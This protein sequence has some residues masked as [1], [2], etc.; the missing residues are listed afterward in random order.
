MR[1]GR[2][3]G[4][5]RPGRGGEDSG[6]GAGT[7][8]PQVL[9]PCPPELGRPVQPSCYGFTF[10]ALGLPEVLALELLGTGLPSADPGLGNQQETADII[11]IIIFF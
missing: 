9:A 5:S 4:E 3:E 7:A 8:K 2:P 6:C 11:I 10:P 1:R